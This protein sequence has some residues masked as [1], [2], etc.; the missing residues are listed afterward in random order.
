MP[1]NGTSENYD[2]YTC[3][4]KTWP[5]Q[6]HNNET[7]YFW[8]MMPEFWNLEAFV[9][10]LR[11]PPTACTARLWGDCN[12]D[13]LWLVFGWCLLVIVDFWC[14]WLIFILMVVNDWL[15]VNLFGVDYVLKPWEGAAVGGQSTEK[16]PCGWNKTDKMGFRWSFRATRGVWKSIYIHP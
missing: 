14:S 16:F 2:V 4:N 9:A 6:K 3:Y 12:I 8:A 5:F 7:W 15:L 11:L 13:W 10:E 1:K